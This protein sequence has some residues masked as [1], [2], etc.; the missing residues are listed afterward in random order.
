MPSG[1]RPPSL[2]LLSSVLLPLG[3]VLAVV[4]AVFATT[5]LAPAPATGGVPSS[6]RA[7]AGGLTTR[8]VLSKPGQARVRALLTRDVRGT[9]RGATVRGVVW[10][11]TS[12]ALAHELVRASRR[13]VSVRLVVGGIDCDGPVV[14][15]LRHHLGRRSFVSCAHDSARGGDEFAGRRTNLH[16][17]TWTFSETGGS[18][19]VSV[20][21]SANATTVADRYQYN[22]AYQSVGDRALFH[23]LREVFHAQVRDRPLAR[24]FRHYRLAPGESV[25]FS[26]WDSPHQADPVVR[27][28]DALPAT[29]TTIRATYSNWQDA[30]GVRVARALA[31]KARHGAD[32]RVLMSRPFSGAVHRVLRRAGVRLHSAYFGPRR[33]SH[34]KFMTARYVEGGAVHTRVWTGSENMWSPS[35]GLDEVVLEVPGP[36]AY[37]SYT[38]FFAD[39]WDDR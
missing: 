30:R 38:G 1:H 29:G 24:P 37:R 3:A 22:D 32:V 7:T 33:Y 2:L 17:K 12:G 9:P 6:V 19:W 5:V 16:Q 14:T 28:I 39:V 4:L 36:A 23:R 34:L 21:T 11:F 20:V 31:V 8:A 15:S 13:G 26:P 25:T 35:R 10:Q 18:R 27:R